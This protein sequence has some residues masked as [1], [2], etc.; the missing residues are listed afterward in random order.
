M[1]SK[2]RFHDTSRF[3]STN[4]GTIDIKIE[5]FYEQDSEMLFKSYLGT[6]IS[7]NFDKN[8]YLGICKSYHYK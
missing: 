8:V 6:K 2:S 7:V 5:L 3:K 1:N 4:Q